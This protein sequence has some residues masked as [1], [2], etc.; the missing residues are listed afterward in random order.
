M[1]DS[2]TGTAKVKAGVIGT[3]VLG[4]YHTR[5]YQENPNVDLV[6]IYDVNTDA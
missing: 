5:L 2:L 6:G 1:A 4:G 3:G